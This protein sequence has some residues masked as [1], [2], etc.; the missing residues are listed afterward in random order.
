MDEHLEYLLYAADNLDSIELPPIF[1][2]LKAL[3]NKP[4]T[5]AKMNGNGHHYIDR[6]RIHPKNFRAK[7]VQELSYLNIDSI[8]QRQRDT[9]QYGRA[10]L[11]GMSMFY[12]SLFTNEI[13]INKA[14]AFMETAEMIH[15]INLDEEF[16]TVSRWRITED[17]SIFECVF[18][19]EGIEVNR[20][21]LQAR[22][23][24]LEFLE[25]ISMSDDFKSEAIEQLK[26][27][28]DQFAKTVDRTNSY[29]YKI[30]SAFTSMMLQHPQNV[31][32][33]PHTTKMHG[34]S[35]PSV[36]SNLQGQNIAL[37]PYAVD[38]FLEFEKAV[39]MKAERTD[40]GIKIEKSF[41]ITDSL[42][43]ENN[44]IWRPF[45]E[46]EFNK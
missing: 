32:N 19:N 42:D 24:Q 25:Q 39:V 40:V 23:K 9:N 10:N 8:L 35:Y 15:N 5:V 11:P 28:G 14:T 12:G 7:K 20:Y 30:S 44:L 45:D 6:I 31:E 4:M 17:F 43:E 26:F 21:T 38:N 27:I 16:L 29:N 2:A 3:P 1:K 13:E 37:S 41:E 46:Q 33:P 18:Q 22:E 34:I 36:Q